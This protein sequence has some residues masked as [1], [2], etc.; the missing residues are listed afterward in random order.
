MA[1]NELPRDLS[2]ANSTFWDRFWSKVEKTETCWLWEGTTNGRGYGALS[3]GGRG[4]PLLYV[5]RAAYEHAYG[6]I[7]VGMQVCHRCDVRS[8]VR[9]EHLFLGTPADNTRDM[10][11]KGRSRSQKVTRC[12]YGHTYTEANTLRKSN[13]ARYCRECRRLLDQKRNAERRRR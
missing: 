10:I 13:G 3:A 12:P 2:A 7:P 1:R 4:S 9:P 11:E 6:P 8:C 5:H